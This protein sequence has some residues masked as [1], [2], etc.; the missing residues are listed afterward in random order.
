MSDTPRTDAKLIQVW[1][2]ETGEIK[3]L[4]TVYASFARVLERGLAAERAKVEQ[5]RWAILSVIPDGPYDPILE[6]Q[7]AYCAEALAATEPTE[8]GRAL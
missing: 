8:E 5:L 3:T 4:D 1:D 7:W 6:P 2:N